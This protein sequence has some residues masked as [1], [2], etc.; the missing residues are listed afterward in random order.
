ME[1]RPHVRNRSSALINACVLFGT[2]KMNGANI[3]I[4]NQFDVEP[5][6]LVDISGLEQ[7]LLEESL[8]TFGMHSDWWKG[9]GWNDDGGEG[10]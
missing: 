5:V 6:G 4:N 3:F 7:S 2:M 9:R 10:N 8:A 1:F